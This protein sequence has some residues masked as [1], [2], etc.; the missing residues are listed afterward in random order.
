MSNMMNNS[1]TEPKI[2]TAQSQKTTQ[3]KDAKDATSTSQLS[4]FLFVLS[5]VCGLFGL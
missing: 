2:S 5:L 3:E 4:I 1:V